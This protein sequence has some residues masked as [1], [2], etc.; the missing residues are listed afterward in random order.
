MHKH[1]ML[2]FTR[3]NVEA[4]V[5]CHFSQTWNIVLVLDLRFYSKKSAAVELYSESLT[6]LVLNYQ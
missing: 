6:I 1:K 4:L 2:P 5:T 3:V